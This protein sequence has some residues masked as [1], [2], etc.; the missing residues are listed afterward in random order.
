LVV[1]FIYIA[2]LHHQPLAKRGASVSQP[3]NLD[4]A[5]VRLTIRDGSVINAGLA[6]STLKT[7]L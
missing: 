1:E 5:F 3:K 2:I 6:I 4:T 7:V